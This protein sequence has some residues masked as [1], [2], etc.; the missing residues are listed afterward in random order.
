M[1]IP[2]RPKRAKLIVGLFLKEKEIVKSVAEKLAAN[3]GQPDA[4][5]PWLSFHHT[6]YYHREMGGPLARRLFAFDDLIAQDRLAD[7]KLLT[8]RIE[9]DFMVD[10]KR[11]VNIDPGYLLAERFVLATGKNYAHRIYLRDGIY[12]DLTL[13]YHDGKF[14]PLDWT[15]PD[16]T[17]EGIL[18]FLKSVREKY[19]WQ[20]KQRD[21]NK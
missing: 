13:T 21:N 2:Q 5:S 3:F 19:L 16:Y 8:N 18:T 4:V 9:D 17:E 15:Y 14:C 10:G 7:I 20:M 12:A 1:S 6:D 11:R